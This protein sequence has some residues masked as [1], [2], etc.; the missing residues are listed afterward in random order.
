MSSSNT[1]ESSTTS[2]TT[3]TSIISKANIFNNPAITSEL[4]KIDNFFRNPIEFARAKARIGELKKE[5]KSVKENLEKLKVKI[6]ELTPVVERRN[7]LTIE[8]NRLTDYID[9]LRNHIIERENLLEIEEQMKIQENN[10]SSELVQSNNLED[11]YEYPESNEETKTES[12]NSDSLSNDNDNENDNSE[13]LLIPV[14]KL[15]RFKDIKENYCS[16][17]WFQ[18]NYVSLNRTIEENYED[19]Q[20]A[21]NERQGKISEKN[22]TN[23]KKLAYDCFLSEAFRFD[24]ERR[25]LRDEIRSLLPMIKKVEKSV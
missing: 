14:V 20:K 25:R 21:R 19:F 16:N 17:E 10:M 13:D 24:S 22:S 18:A 12:A 8:I 23:N 6:L 7:E 1:S 4:S 5:K 15:Q 11:I 3:T 9:L 2:T